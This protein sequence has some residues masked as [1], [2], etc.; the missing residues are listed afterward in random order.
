MDYYGLFPKFKTN[1]PLIDGER[2]HQLKQKER[3]NIPAT[4]IIS[5]SSIIQFNSNQMELVDKFY[6]SKGLAGLLGFFGFCCCLF[7]LTS[8]VYF[9]IP[10]E[11]WISWGDAGFIIVFIVITVPMGG[12]M[13]YILR[14]EWFAWTHYPV[15][16]DRKS[17]MI[18]AHRTDGSTYSVLWD[19]VFF[20]SGLNHQ[21]D[22]NKDFYISGHVLGND[23]KT[24]I[25]TFCLPATHSDREQLAR[26]WEFVRRYMEEGPAAVI[27][28][29]DFC[30]PIEKKRESYTF[31]VLYILSQFAGV[32]IVLFPICFVLS[33]IFSIP[34]HIAIITSRRPTWPDGIKD[35]YPEY[36]DDPYLI[37]E[38]NNSNHLWRD[39]FSKK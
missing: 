28:A 36:P 16:F 4:E 34:R 32:S 24:V 20:T 11:G 17:K 26:H 33:I 5:D 39:I 7:M 3:I 22:F 23:K 13:L 9:T 37:T 38:K 10:D 14:T 30:L 1:R 29:V 15:L 31:G 21:K 35:S 2:I 25:D 8:A 6:S 18:H 12:W 27:N 19:K